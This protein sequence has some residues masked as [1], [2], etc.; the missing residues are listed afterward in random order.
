MVSWRRISWISGLLFA[1][2]VVLAAYTYRGTPSHSAS[3]AELPPL[4][5]I[6]RREFSPE[7]YRAIQDTFWSKIQGEERHCAE[8]FVFT[9]MDTLRK[10][11]EINGEAKDIGGGCAHMT[12]AMSY[13]EVLEA[14]LKHCGIPYSLERRGLTIRSSRPRIVA[15]ATCLRYASTCPPPRCGAA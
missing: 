2:L 10:H 9:Y 13:P 11:C 12:N 5:E 3:Q 1:G 6:P 4:V 14:G 15:S 7:E 8:A